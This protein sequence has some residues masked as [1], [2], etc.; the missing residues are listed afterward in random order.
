MIT[1]KHKIFINASPEKVWKEFTNLG[2]W[3][4]MNS[5]YKYAKHTKGNPWT[6]GAMFEFQS[7]YGFLKTK[8]KPVIL[9]VNAPNFIEWIGTKPFIKGKHSF[10]FRKIKNG[11]E[12]VNYEEFKGIGL[13]IINILKLKPK[14]EKSFELFMQGLKRE[15]E[16]KS[17][18]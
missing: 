16:R 10:T 3:P 12:V 1:I 14:I 6:K 15:A 18:I 9:R 8:A 2:K 4:K 17:W 7:D 13:P 11:T 5:F